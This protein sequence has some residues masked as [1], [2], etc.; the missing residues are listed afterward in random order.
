MILSSDEE[1]LAWKGLDNFIYSFNIYLWGG[2]SC[3]GHIPDLGT[4]PQELRDLCGGW[5]GS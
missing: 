3:A 2:L 4:Q 5:A 1:T